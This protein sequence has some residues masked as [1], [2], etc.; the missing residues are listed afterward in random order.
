MRIEE[1]VIK[2]WANWLVEIG[3][4]LDFTDEASLP[5]Y[6]K[7]PL[8]QAWYEKDSIH[9]ETVEDYYDSLSMEL[10]WE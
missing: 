8:A 3:Y 7:Q 6:M 1:Q 9:G 10:G 2:D 4:G 5:S